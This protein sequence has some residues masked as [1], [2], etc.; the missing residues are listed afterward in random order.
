MGEFG[1]NLNRVFIENLRDPEMRKEAEERSAA[2]VKMRVY[3]DSFMS[4]ILPPKPIS[5]AQCDRV[6]AGAG[7]DPSVLLR[8]VIDREYTDV[9]A[10][11]I[12]FRGQADYKFVETETYNID[13][14]KIDSEEYEITEGELRAKEQPVQSLI[15][16]HTAYFI[17]HRMDERFLGAVDAAIALDAANQSIDVADE[18][19]LPGNLVRLFNLLDAR[20]DAFPQQ[21]ATLL[22]TRAQYNAI[23]SWPQT[24]TGMGLQQEYWKDG[25]RYDTLFGRRIVK[26]IKGDLLANTR[27]HLFAAPEFL[28]HH[29][30]FNDDRFQIWT[31]WDRIQ[32]KAWKTHGAGI[33]NVRSVAQ[34]NMNVVV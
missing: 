27:V 12:P 15:K 24:V 16:H 19:I 11:A 34:M 4:R 17:Q 26:T 21:S 9:A 22:M 33:G 3:E 8:K 28:G 1:V 7:G 10:I 32:W 25:Y 6:P 13:F 18:I 23:A 20:V 5:P 14:Y 2:F 31:K 30:T 29:L